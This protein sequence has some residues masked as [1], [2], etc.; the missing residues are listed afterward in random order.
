MAIVRRLRS[1]R[2]GPLLAVALVF[3]TVVVAVAYRT[4]ARAAARVEC[5]QAPKALLLVDTTQHAL[6][7]CEDGRAV[8]TFAVRL[9]RAGTGKSREGD[10][11]TPLG[12]YSIGE[13]RVSGSYGTFVPVNYP[14]V[15]QARAGYTGGAIGVHGP[16]RRVRWA[17]FLVNAFD[18]TDG[19]VGIAT[20]G[21]MTRIAEWVRRRGAKD[22]VLN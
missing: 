2:H 18:T 10:Q 6:A 8:E 14:T 16:D 22:V 15:E 21:E 1:T 9:G 19:C 7:L 11:K 3:G 13:P 5:P 4:I 20:D 17:G 12:A